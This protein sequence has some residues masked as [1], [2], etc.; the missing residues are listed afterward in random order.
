M[1]CARSASTRLG[2]WEARL[3]TAEHRG[4]RHLE[5]GGSRMIIFLAGLQG[6]PDELYDAASIDGANGWHRFWAVTVPMISPV[7]F[8][9]II[10]ST[11]AAFR[12]FTLA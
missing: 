1:R 9:N 10:I 5:F 12:V 4:D 7:I 3:G 6:V 8:F 11:I 2:G